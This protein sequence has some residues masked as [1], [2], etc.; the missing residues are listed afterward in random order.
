MRPSA[1]IAA[2]LVAA[3]G[4]VAVGAGEPVRVA[5]AGDRELARD[6]SWAPP[7]ADDLRRRAVAWASEAAGPG[8]VPQ[9]EAIWD[10]LTTAGT[11]VDLVD[12]AMETAAAVDPRAADLRAAPGGPGR[13]V[14]WLDASSASDFGRQAVKLWLGRELVRRDR[15][16]EALPLLADLDVATAIDPAT[17]LFH[18]GCCQHWLLDREA[19]LESFDRLL[20]RSDELPA[21]YLRLARL[22][23]ADIAGVESDSLDHIA[24]RMRDVRR[25]L[26]LGRAGPETRRVQQGVLES[27]DKLIEDLEKQ[28]QQRQGQAGA[29]GAGGG[30]PGGA[31]GRPMDDSRIARGQGKGEVRNRDLGTGDGWGDLPPHEREAALQQIGREY[32]PHYREAIEEYFKRLATGGEDA[33]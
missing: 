11:T 20:E 1:I 22:L 2:V 3:A 23:R 9:V 21:R 19:A 29:A 28:Q 10:R 13:D 14:A 27:L 12:V 24:R 26:D 25:R 33:P 30:G 6:P 5:P 32:P 18:R 7:S 4:G 15:F 16:D 17:L 31:A 8:A